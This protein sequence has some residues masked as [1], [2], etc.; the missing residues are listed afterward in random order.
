MNINPDKETLDS[1]NAEESVE[2]FASKLAD[3]LDLPETLSN[4]VEKSMKDAGKEPEEEKE[5]ETEEQEETEESEESDEQPETDEDDEDL[6]PKSKVQ[7]RFNEL[8]RQNRDLQARLQKMEEGQKKAE[9]ETRDEDEKKLQAMSEEEL[10]VLKRQVRLAQVKNSSDDTQLAKLIDLEEKIDRSIS[11]APQRFTATQEAKF[12]EEVKASSSEIENF[13]KVGK[14]IHS[15]AKTIFS[16]SPEL[17]KSVTGQAR[18]W[19]LAMEHYKEVSKLSSGKSKEKDLERKVNTL[20]RKVSI[21]TP[22]EKG[23]EQDN[24]MNKSFKKA[25]Y[26]SV[27]DKAEFI[28]KRLNTDS[29]VEAELRARGS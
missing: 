17:Q 23:S 21:D 2:A 1:A 18:A 13:D 4:A 26:G 8:T 7:E 22:S 6:I 27:D 12:F 15:Y 11:S 16:S 9:E 10:R 3:S 24:S 29:L 14:E 5:E 25:K 19:R 20:K 28:R